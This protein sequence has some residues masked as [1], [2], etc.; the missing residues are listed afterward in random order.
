M[1]ETTPYETQEE[2]LEGRLRSMGFYVALVQELG[3]D[4][5]K[6]RDTISRMEAAGFPEEYT[7]LEPV[8]QLERSATLQVEPKVVAFMK[9]YMELMAEAQSQTEAPAET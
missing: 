6:V 9:A 8:K 4:L 5:S 1:T 7:I 2:A 3:E